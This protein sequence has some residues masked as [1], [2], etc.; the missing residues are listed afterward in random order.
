MKEF[1]DRYI[2]KGEIPT[3]ARKAGVHPNTVYSWRGERNH[4]SM[5]MLVWF[6]R[7]L[8]AHTKIPYENLWL[9]LI[10]TVEGVTDAYQKSQGWIQS[11]KHQEQTDDEEESS[12]TVESD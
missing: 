11:C 5:M 2:Q 3:I 12:E 10:Y 6:L 8:A 7:A 1:L 9:D 4:P